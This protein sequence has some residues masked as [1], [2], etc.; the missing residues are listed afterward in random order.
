MKKTTSPYIIVKKSK[1]HGKGIFAKT[2]IPAGARVIEY[3]GEKITKAESDRRYQRALERSQNG[4][5]DK[6]IVYIFTLNKHYDLDGDVPWNTASL[7][8]HSCDPNSETESI[9][10]HIWITALRDIKKGEEILY[11]YGYD[12]E[13]WQEHPCNCGSKRCA[14]YIMDEDFW[15]VLKRKIAQIEQVTSLGGRPGRPT[16]SPYIAVKKSKIHGTGVFAKGKISPNTY[17][18]EYVGEKITKKESDRRYQEAWD[19]ARDGGNDKGTVYLFTLDDRFDID[20]DV[21]WNTA[22]FIN[23]SCDPNCE[24]DIMDGHIFIVSLK[25]IEKGEE[26]SYNYGYDFESWRDHPCKC[27]AN[28]CVGYIL[29]EE[30]WPK[31]KRK[32][33][34][35]KEHKGRRQ[36]KKKR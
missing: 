30:H 31:L 4:G 21:K 19:K 18:I 13:S 2:A 28:N 6:G 10:G 24:T 29:D 26:F 11:N 36:V 8:N 17:V 12:L 33:K 15:P 35:L 3:V 25:N 27:G 1:I 23:H 16:K 34:Q 22:R 32:L 9:R 5:G 7:I 20:G 14:G